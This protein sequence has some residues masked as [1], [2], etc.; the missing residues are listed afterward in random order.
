MREKI[1]F[2]LLNLHVMKIKF[3]VVLIINIT[4]SNFIYSQSPDSTLTFLASL[5]LSTYKDNPVDSF[6]TKVPGGYIEMKVLA[7]HNPKIANVLSVLYPNKIYVWVYVYKFQF[8]NPRSE[9]F[10]WNMILFRK[11]NVHHIEV[12]KN[13][14]C[15]NGCPNGI[16]T[17]PIAVERNKNN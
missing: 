17:V 11:E 16:P 6:L 4:L 9:T 7:S 10:T 5:N 1:S 2:N 3:L 14:D 8:M 13:V 12:W 15:Y